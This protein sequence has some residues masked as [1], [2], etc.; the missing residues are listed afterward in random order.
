[1]DADQDQLGEIAGHVVQ[2]DRP[3][4]AAARI[5]GGIDHRLADLQLD[6]HAQ[7]DAFGVERII[8]R[9]VGRQL[10]PMRIGMCTDKAHVLDRALQRPHPVHAFGGIDAS[11]AVK[12]LGILLH[13]ALDQFIRQMIAGGM[14]DRP[15]LGRDQEG[16]LD[17]GG[18]HAPQHL[19]QRHAVHGGVVHLH[20]ALIERL[21]V[22][23]PVFA[24]FFGED[25]GDDVDGF[26][27][28]HALPSLPYRPSSRAMM[29][30]WIS[31][32]PSPKE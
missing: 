11:Q 6:R 7:L 16:A 9:V 4:H 19:L 15:V 1:M 27:V 13:R 8:A 14:A 10:E 2:S 32:E 28:V 5:I 12:A 31:L 21:A 20:L 23:G 3:A 18:I 30:R 29:S 26:D 22:L 24:H 25:V 17:A